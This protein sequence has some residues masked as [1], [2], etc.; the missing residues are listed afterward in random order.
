MSSP[1]FFG[2]WNNK[3]WTL[4]TCLLS[5]VTKKCSLSPKV[6]SWAG[7]QVCHAPRSP[8]REKDLSQKLLTRPRGPILGARAEVAP[9]SPP[10]A[11]RHT[12]STI[13]TLENNPFCNDSAK[14][15][16]T[17][18]FAVAPLGNARERPNRLTCDQKEAFCFWHVLTTVASAIC[19][20]GFDVCPPTESQFHSQNSNLKSENSNL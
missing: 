10:T 11:R 3:L 7:T 4:Q 12:E 17:L 18:A 9:T 6:I 15:Q 14:T 13:S 20:C 1:T 19:N 16:P 2:D 8:T 5:S